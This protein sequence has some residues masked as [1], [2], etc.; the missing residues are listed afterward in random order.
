MKLS[1]LC[2][3]A[4]IAV[5][6]ELLLLRIFTRRIMIPEFTNP[7]LFIPIWIFD[8]ERDAGQRK[9]CFP[10]DYNHAGEI[11]WSRGCVCV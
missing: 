10:E 1:L 9:V 3:V 8:K 2:V 7:L 5:L 11:A 6:E 4:V